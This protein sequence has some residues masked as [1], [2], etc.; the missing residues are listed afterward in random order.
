VIRDRSLLALLTAEL[1]S[2]LGSQF[3]SLALP[4]FVLV[5]TGSAS[6]M[7]LVFAVELA[8]IVLL[9]IPSAT[10]VDRLGPRRWLVTTD[11]VRAP[12]VAAVPFLHAVGGLSYGLILALGALHG[13]CSVGYF[14]SQRLILPSVVGEDERRLAQANGL[15]EG[16]TNLTNLAGPALAGVLIALL[17]AANVMWL[18]AASYAASA[19]TI[20]LFVTVGRPPAA[21]EREDVGGVFAGLRYLRRDTLLARISLSSLAFGFVFPML[22]ASFPVLAYRQYDR[23]ARVAGLL[24]AVIGAGQLAGS[25]LT[26]KL[27]TKV[28]PMLLASVA[29]LGTGP[30]LWLLVPHL[31][32]AVVGLALAVCGASIPLINAPY[33]GML[34]LRVPKALRG[35]VL[36]SLLTIN[37]LAGPLGYVVAGTMFAHVGLHETYALIAALGTFATLNF[38]V[39]AAPVRGLLAQEAA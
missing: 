39:A 36:Q 26:Y 33:I 15:V 7:G 13:C 19:L 10:L 32:L 37:Q 21:G 9:G 20:G 31:P 29:C 27:V 28:K 23:N 2:R 17:G 4:W 8:P 18:D 24:L 34:T 38:V 1:V 25:L 6:K 12:I 5:T 14:N 35:H 11:A 30:P 22:V 16:T 3:T